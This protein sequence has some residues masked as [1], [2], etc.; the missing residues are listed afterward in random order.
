MRRVFTG[1]VHVPTS[2]EPDVRSSCSNEGSD[3]TI[4]EGK[5]SGRMQE[6]DARSGSA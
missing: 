6:G 3:A 1:E 2:L 4:A 5:G